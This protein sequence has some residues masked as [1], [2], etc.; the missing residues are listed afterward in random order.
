LERFKTEKLDLAAFL[1]AKG[2]PVTGMEWVTDDL[3][4]FTFGRP[5]VENSFHIKSIA[6]SFY[7]GE[8]VH[9][10]HYFKCV[11]DIKRKM[12]KTKKQL[13]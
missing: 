6:D 3:C 7:D 8:L 12:F 13:I 4:V 11:T 2:I 10:H 5:D 1:V 9:A